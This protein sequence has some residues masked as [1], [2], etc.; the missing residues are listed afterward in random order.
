M[1][2][3]LGRVAVVAAALLALGVMGT[4]AHA[5]TESGNGTWV[6][7]TTSGW[8]HTVCGISAHYYGRCDVARI[9]AANPSINSQ[10]LIHAG[11]SYWV[12]LGASRTPAPA[13]PS[14]IGWVRPIGNACVT[15]GYGPRWGSFH[16]GYDLLRPWG[17]PIRAAASGT[18]IGAGWIHRGYGISV[19]IAHSGGI[20]TH[21]GHMSVEYVRPGQHITAGEI[22]GR[23]GNTGHIVSSNYSQPHPGS[24]LHFEVRRGSGIW[25]ASINPGAWMLAHSARLGC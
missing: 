22:I 16:A 23:V 15:S 3:G 7:A 13:S 19:M 14:A 6:T 17:M 18:V 11:R 20:K 8:S 2:R 1:L 12:P 5:S 24:H 9:R 10:S 4:P 25:P 21:Y